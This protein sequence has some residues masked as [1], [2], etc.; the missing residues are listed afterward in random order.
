M[1]CR[2][3]ITHIHSN[4]IH[5]VVKQLTTFPMDL[6]KITIYNLLCVVRCTMCSNTPPPK[7]LCKL[8]GLDEPQYRK[9]PWLWVT[10]MNT[11]QDGVIMSIKEQEDSWRKSMTLWSVSITKQILP[12]TLVHKAYVCFSLYSCGQASLAYCT[13]SL[14]IWVSTLIVSGADSSWT[15]ANLKRIFWLFCP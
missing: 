15:S 1:R 2:I 13:C 6:Q 4:N 5:V 14:C 3:I 9:K 12:P 10:L 7:V 11:H 8:L